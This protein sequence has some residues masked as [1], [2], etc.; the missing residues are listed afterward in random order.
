M[1]GSCGSLKTYLSIH[2]EALFFF[3]QRARLVLRSSG[4]EVEDIQFQHI[5]EGNN[6]Q[7]TRRVRSRR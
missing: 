2:G 7:G 5:G 4:C 3:S 1:M 6:V